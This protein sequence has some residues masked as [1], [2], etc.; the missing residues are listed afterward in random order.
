MARNVGPAFIA[1]GNIAPSR[2][3]RPN[4]SLD[5]AVQQAAAAELPIGISQ[6]CMQYAQFDLGIS[7]TNAATSGQPINV[8]TEGEECLLELGGTV[9]AGV[10]LK[11]DSDGK[12]VLGTLGTDAVG[13]TSLEAGVSGDLIR[14]QVHIDNP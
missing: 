5:H 6:E 12:G 11:P 13:A 10:R 7:N 14:V 2:F 4:V 1:T 9:T 8:Y 3:V